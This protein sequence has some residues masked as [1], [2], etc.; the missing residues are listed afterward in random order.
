MVDGKEVLEELYLT[1]QVE[2]A[3]GLSLKGAAS[4][5]CAPAAYVKKQT[6]SF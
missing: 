5:P 2:A 6:I 4:A 1:L 3:T